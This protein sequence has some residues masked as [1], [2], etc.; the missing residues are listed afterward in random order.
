MPHEAW[1]TSTAGAVVAGGAVSAMLFVG[2]WPDRIVAGLVGAIVA[3][4]GTPI[5]S[6]LV[7]VAV[8]SIYAQ[9]GADVAQVPQD[10]ITGVTGLLLGVSGIHF[11]VWFVD[12]L[13]AFLTALRLPFTKTP[14]EK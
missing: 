3:W 9:A 2:P 12:R 10:S 4:F 5:F 7:Y 1:H 13:K 11:V 6:P 14:P 8:A